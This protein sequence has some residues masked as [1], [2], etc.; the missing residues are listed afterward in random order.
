MKTSSYPFIIWP[1]VTAL[2]ETRGSK[3]YDLLHPNEKYSPPLFPHPNNK[4]MTSPPQTQKYGPSPHIFSYPQKH[5]EISLE[6]LSDIG[7]VVVFPS[8]LH[9]SNS[10]KMQT[11]NVH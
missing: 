4:T 7:Y 5:S 11:T 3:K 1:G 10:L 9:K 6:S 2:M 8:I